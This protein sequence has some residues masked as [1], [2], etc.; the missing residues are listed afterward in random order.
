M[1][2][3]IQYELVGERY[4][5]VYEDGYF[6][7][8]D[9]GDFY[10][11]SPWEAW[12]F[13]TESHRRHWEFTH[14]GRPAFESFELADVFVFADQYIKDIER[15]DEETYTEWDV[16]YYMLPDDIERADWRKEGF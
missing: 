12:D 8:N 16:E 5:V 4:W 1:T 7:R 11:E 14:D 6:V 2:D 10:I 9:F 13:A 3:E 15:L